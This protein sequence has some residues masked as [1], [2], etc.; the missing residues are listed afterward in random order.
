MPISKGT[1]RPGKNS[2]TV[3]TDD[4]DGFPP[5][6]GHGDTN[7]YGGYLIAESI[8]K[9][10]DV[11]LI[12][13]AKDLLDSLVCIVDAIDNIKFLEPATLAKARAAIKKATE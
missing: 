13:A 8:G 6:T 12:S 7:Y 2:D 9:R 1:W 11:K 10:D 5:N 4:P 3:V